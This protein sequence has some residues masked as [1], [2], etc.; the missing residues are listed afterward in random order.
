[1][2]IFAAER[3]KKMKKT[4]TNNTS[5]NN[6]SDF[7]HLKVWQDIPDLDYYLSEQNWNFHVNQML[8]KSLLVFYEG[9][10]LGAFLE[11]SHDTFGQPIKDYTHKYGKMF[12]EAYRLCRM[13]LTSP[14]PETKIAQFAM[15]AA[16]WKFRNMKDENGKTYHLI[17]NVT[18]LIESYH[19]LG[20][21]NTI[22]IFA[23][24][25]TESVDRFLVALSVYKDEGLPFKGYIHCFDIYNEVY[26]AFILTTIVDGTYLRPGYDYKAKDEYLRKNLPWYNSLA[27]ELDKKMKEA[28][29]KKRKDSAEANMEQ[30][31]LDKISANNID[32]YYEG[33]RCGKAGAI[34]QE[35][36]IYRFI[37]MTRG[38]SGMLHRVHDRTQDNPVVAIGIV[39]YWLIF[40]QGKDI[41]LQKLTKYTSIPQ[42]MKEMFELYT[43][44]KF[45][46]FKEQNRDNPDSWDWD[47]D[48][49]F[50]SKHIII[51]EMELNKLSEALFDYISDEDIKLVKSVM[52]NYINY[53]KKENQ[54]KGYSTS[55]EIPVTE[56]AEESQCQTPQT[57]LTTCHRQ[58]IEDEKWDDRY[59]YI[60]NDKVK[61]R[62]IKKAMESIVL[63]RKISKIRFFYVT[64]RIL[65]I[66][67]Y[68][69]DSS[70]RNDFLR[71]VNIHLNCGWPDDKQHKRRFSF[72]LEDSSKNLE[73]QHPSEWDE[74]TIKGGSGIY[75]HQLAITLK[76][77]FTQTVVNGHHVDDSDS[78]DHLIDRG[79]FLLK[80]VHLRDNDY[81]IPE[82]A[83]INNGK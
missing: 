65:E 6:D 15:Q 36:G 50:Y 72:T 19:I 26:K 11:V 40:K 5:L 21:V 45:Q 73:T 33:W 82:D 66:L 29:A 52:T 42:S 69:P 28:E 56:H 67:N 4:T 17:P 71:W 60:F 47:W 77:T 51:Q 34:T 13:V 2:P 12:N 14:V 55:P 43:Q 80:A 49:E 54:S 59:D 62:E 76:N 23:N 9:Q 53:L 63:P 70:S 83:Y 39:A 41:V 20:M 38:S 37:E 64:C 3:N 16:T 61:P 68:I 74:N 25:Q 7:E 79:R 78:F 8:H 81:Y 58:V 24:D 35:K 27:K 75:H 1:M 22:L 18:D 46:L 31:V 44:Q 32:Y 48:K 30:T 10:E 57:N